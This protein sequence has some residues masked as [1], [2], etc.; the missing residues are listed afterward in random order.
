MFNDV[1][2]VEECRDLLRRLAACAFP[3]QCAHGRP[4]MV[5]L[6]DLGA[7]GDAIDLGVGGPVERGPGGLMGEL[8]RWALKQGESS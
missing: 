2:T 1:L 7:G 5:P 6:V 4:S 3:F 8:K